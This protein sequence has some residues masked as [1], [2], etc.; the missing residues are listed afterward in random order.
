M[1]FSDEEVLNLALADNEDAK[2]I[3]YEKF[4]YIV[5]IML[6]KYN[7]AAFKAGIDIHELEQEAYYAFSDALISFREDKNAKIATFIS[8]CIDRRLKKIIRKSTG[9]KAKVLN[10]TYSLDYDYDEDGTTLKDCLSDYS[11]NDP[12]YNLTVKENYDELLKKIKQNLSSSEYEVFSYI[13]N[14]FDY[15]TIAELTNRNPKQIDNTIQRVKH[16]IRDIISD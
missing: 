5:D 4:K 9:E 7:N 14:D 15:L 11:Q 12:L 1:E 13:V 3:I 2:N 16:K 10:N 6:K 8:I